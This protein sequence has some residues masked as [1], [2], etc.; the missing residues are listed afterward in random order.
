[1]RASLFF[2]VFNMHLSNTLILSLLFFG[3]VTIFYV[4]ISRCKDYSNKIKQILQVQ[5]EKE[6]SLLKKIEVSELEIKELVADNNMRLLFKKQFLEQLKEDHN[7]NT[8]AEIKN[9]THGLILKMKLQIGTENKLSIL[10]RKVHKLNTE[11]QSKIIE[12]YP[13]ITKTER[14]VCSLLRLNLS[15]KEVASIRNATVGSVKIIRHRIRKKLDVPSGEELE[16]FVQ[17]L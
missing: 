10:Q 4:Y 11:F 7:L 12:L 5:R 13:N 6:K 16:H 17:S 8:S 14:E 2:V 1:M 15:I 3:M 9:Y